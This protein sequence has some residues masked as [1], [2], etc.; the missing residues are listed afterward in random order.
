MSSHMAQTRSHPTPVRSRTAQTLDAMDQIPA[1]SSPK[2]LA[3]PNTQMLWTAE[4]DILLLQLIDTHGTSWKKIAS[5]MF[6]FGRTVAMCRNRYQ[7]MTVDLSKCPQRAN[8]CR[9]CGQMKRGH[10]CGVRAAG[11]AQDAS[12]AVPLHSISA[13]TSSMS[14]SSLAVPSSSSSS[15]SVSSDSQSNKAFVDVRIVLAGVRPKRAAPDS[16]PLHIPVAAPIAKRSCHEEKPLRVQTPASASPA[17]LDSTPFVGDP[18]PSAKALDKASPSPPTNLFPVVL[19]PEQTTRRVMEGFK[20]LSALR[21]RLDPA[22]LTFERPPPPP[23]SI[24]NGTSGSQWATS[25][26]PSGFLTPPWTQLLEPAVIE[27]EPYGAIDGDDDRCTPILATPGARDHR[28]EHEDETCDVDDELD[29]DTEDGLDGE[30]FAFATAVGVVSC[31]WAASYVED[32]DKWPPD[33]PFL[34]TTEEDD[35]PSAPVSPRRLT[36]DLPVPQSL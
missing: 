27:H 17:P 33:I 7:R 29:V 5:G 6:A 9:R 18:S 34:V 26:Y 21:P 2:V 12:D 23:V 19:T 25:S 16:V 24:S 20:R 36:W 31:P 28:E 22:T 11:K 14:P 1:T 15:S 35:G 3:P 13:T 8:T 10:T 30:T 4:E 32:A